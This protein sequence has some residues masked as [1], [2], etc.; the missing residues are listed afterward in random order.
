MRRIGF[1]LCL[2]G[3]VLCFVGVGGRSE[4]EWGERGGWGGGEGRRRGGE[5]SGGGGGGGGTTMIR[6][7]LVLRVG[8]TLSPV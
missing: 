6:L 2:L 8:I 3:L 1:M 4:R 7:M 5:S